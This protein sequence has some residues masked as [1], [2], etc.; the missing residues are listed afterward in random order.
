MRETP[1]KTAKLVL[2]LK[3]MVRDTVVPLRE[4]P[5][6]RNDRENYPDIGAK[7]QWERSFF[8]TNSSSNSF[9]CQSL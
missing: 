6:S 8:R 9:S 3:R 5:K 4:W 7:R 2:R 1:A